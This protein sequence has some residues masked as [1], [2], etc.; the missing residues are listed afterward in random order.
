MKSEQI[1]QITN[2]AV[3]QLIAALNEGRSETLT[4]YLVSA[5]HGYGPRDPCHTGCPYAQGGD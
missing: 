2:K 3:E 1:K 5:F 4:Q